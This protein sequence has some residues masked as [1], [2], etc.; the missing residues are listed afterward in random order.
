MKRNCLKRNHR[1][2]IGRI[3][4]WLFL[5]LC[6]VMAACGVRGNTLME[7]AAVGNSALA[8]YYYDGTDTARRHMFDTDQIRQVLYELAAVS[9]KRVEDW[10][11]RELGAPMYG[12]CMMKEDG[13][14]LAAVW[15]EGLWITQDGQAY[16]FDYD[17]G[18]LWEA[19]EWKSSDT[20]SGQMAIP[21][22]HAMTYMDG[23]GDAPWDGS[24]D[25]TWMTEGWELTAPEGV[26]M[27]LVEWG[28]TSV[29]VKLL[30]HSGQEWAFGEYYHLEVL[31]DGVWY[32]VPTAPGEN[33]MVHDIAYMLPDG[34]DMEMT[35]SLVCYGDLPAGH[36]RLVAEAFQEGL[37]V[38]A[39]IA[40]SRGE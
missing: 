33:W 6:V 34:G 9:V 13:R 20:W 3:G 30:N 17:S 37:A 16:A 38:E 32:Q 8:V 1:L 12:L 19:G 10:S 7:G 11:P 23:A 40:V 28:D 22:Q 29:T 5:M 36:Y 14:P 27:E 26:S 25:P 4:T 35:Y 39:D 31:L 21:C 18:A 24:W 15:S 2:G